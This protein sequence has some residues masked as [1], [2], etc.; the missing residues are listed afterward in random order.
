MDSALLKKLQAARPRILVVGDIMLDRYTWGTAERVSPEAPVLILRA[1]SE[2][3]RLGGAASVAALL[4]GLLATVSIA[5]VVGADGGAAVVRR[6]LCE[7]KIDTSLLFEDLFRPT[8]VKERILGRPE[9]RVSGQLLRVDHE[10]RAPLDERTESQVLNGA[11]SQLNQFQALLISDYG[12]GVCTPYLLQSLIREAHTLGIPV[13]VD[14]ER[15]DDF[16]KYWGATLLKPNRPAA[17]L[18]SNTPVTTVKEALVAAEIIRSSLE[19]SSVVI[20]LDRDGMVWQN[21]ECDRG[22]VPPSASHL[23]DITGAGDMAHAMLGIC[24]AT[25]VPVDQAVELANLAAGLEVERDGVT[26]VG[27]DE[28]D[29]AA[30][31]SLDLGQKVLTV[32]QLERLAGK[33]RTEQKRIVF[34]NGCF[35]LLHIGHVTYLQE[36]ARLGDI[37]VVAVN[38]DEAVQRLKGKS[39][40]VI[41]ERDRAAMLAALSCVSY[42][43]VFGDDTPHALLRRLRPDVLVKGGTYT[44][45]EV[46]G[47]EIVNAYG[48]QVSVV[49]RVD[50]VSTTRLL[51]RITSKSEPAGSS[52]ESSNV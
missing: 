15:R 29:A 21:A 22:H 51:D 10:S 47:R 45:Q 2:E 50:G 11:L 17:A 5:G 18:A 41:S 36:A 33:Y 20:T 30:L 12:K 24:L 25:D 39:R 7:A 37:L 26:P 1:D 35:D 52:K 3:V 27:W 46:V 40:P 19:V 8:T 38:S 34:T 49:G 6:L 48:G 32:A 9:H 4:R 43:I 16:A 44:E 14:P 23:R 13:L 42:V 31:G 28:I